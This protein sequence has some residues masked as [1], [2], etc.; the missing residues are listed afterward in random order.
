MIRLLDGD[1]LLNLFDPNIENV[2]APPVDDSFILPT[3]KQSKT[4]GTLLPG[5]LFYLHC[6]QPSLWES[7]DTRMNN[8]EF[9]SCFQFLSEE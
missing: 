4:V 2:K 3:F 6:T 1:Q 8:S 5:N 9:V 7:M